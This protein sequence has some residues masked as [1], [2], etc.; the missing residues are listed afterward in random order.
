MKASFILCVGL[1]VCSAFGQ[2]AFGGSNELLVGSSVRPAVAV[3]G[4]LTALGGRVVVDQAVGS[5]A[6]LLGGTV[7]VRSSVGGD[8]RA[9]G[10]DVALEGAV[11]G[12]VLAAA[13]SL[14]LTRDARV[15]GS[16]RLTG[17]DVRVEGP[18]DGGLTV[19]ARRLFL[20]APVGGSVQSTVEE[21]QLGPLARVGGDLRYSAAS[22]VQDPAAVVSGVVERVDWPPGNGPGREGGHPMRD[23]PRTGMGSWW[24]LLPL[25]MGLLGVLSVAG[26]VLFVF[27]QFAGRAAQQ[28]ETRPW[29]AL[30]LGAACLLAVPML[31]MLLFFTL[32]GIPLGLVVMALYPPLLLLGWLIG[33]LYAARWLSAHASSPV[34][35]A[36]RPVP[37]GW[38][39][40]AVIGLLV[41]GAV[42]VAG[43]LLMTA[44]MA[45]G[46]GACVLEWRRRL[47]AT[48]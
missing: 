12:D 18:V 48:A 34:D 10:G 42:P 31:A 23:G 1:A 33:A 37:Y 40:A 22:V 28:I 38:M 14:R 11:G 19:R 27:S 21:I 43:P 16:A 26:V 35:L 20:N 46:V 2:P 29:L 17:G 13:G 45:A 3:D 41:V 25:S 47:S 5:D 24:L 44:C 4:D 30:G 9:A 6:L 39:V 8:L 7:D 32:L 15:A 36:S